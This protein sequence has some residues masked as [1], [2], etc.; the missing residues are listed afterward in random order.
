M[1]L[2]HLIP[3][4]LYNLPHR[5]PHPHLLLPLPLRHQRLLQPAAYRND[6]SKL[7]RRLVY[8]GYD[9]SVAYSQTPAQQAAVAAV[10][11]DTFRDVAVAYRTVRRQGELDPPARAA[12]LAAYKRRFPDHTHEQADATVA[13]IIA[14]AARDYQEWFWK[15]V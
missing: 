3:L 12:A 14:Q 7:W 11:R 2:G 9:P 13:V 1:C 5:L 8:A 6:V 4:P 10:D 15:G